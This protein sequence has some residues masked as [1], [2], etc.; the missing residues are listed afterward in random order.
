MMC[1]GA[2]PTH[3]LQA[4][5]RSQP[6]QL[7]MVSLFWLPFKIFAVLCLETPLLL[8]AVVVLPNATVT[9]FVLFCL[10]L[11]GH[12]AWFSLSRVFFLKSLESHQSSYSAHRFCGL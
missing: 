12:F 10:S 5:W 11:Q 3:L 4:Q 2:V 7:L 6:A 9:Y 1:W 8:S